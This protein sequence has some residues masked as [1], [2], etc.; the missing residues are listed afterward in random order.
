MKKICLFLFF[1]PII[2]QAQTQIDS[3]KLITTMDDSLEFIVYSSI[4]GGAIPEH[5]IEYEEN[6]N[7]VR[8][9]IFYSEVFPHIDCYC[10]VQTTIKI[11]KDIYAKAIVSIM[12]RI[13]TGGTEENLEYS[14]YQFKD[15]REILLSQTNIH[16]FVIDDDI[17]FYPNPIKNSFYVDLK[18]KENLCLKI[19]NLQGALLFDKN[20][21][22]SQSVDVSFL[23]SGLYVIVI[24]KKNIYKIVK[25]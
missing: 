23:P 9:N 22:N 7:N 11:K 18:G 16:D 20:I 19:Y 14:D 24:G 3:I 1:L 2:I 4:M 17:L 6:A 8:V 12:F 21:I 13:A 15:S 25:K 10:P 5:C